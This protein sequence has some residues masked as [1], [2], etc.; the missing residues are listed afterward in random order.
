MAPLVSEYVHRGLRLSSVL[1]PAKHIAITGMY[2]VITGFTTFTFL[3]VLR[4]LANYVTR[5]QG[6]Q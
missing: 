2:F 3:L 1:D 4:A 5:A 6:H